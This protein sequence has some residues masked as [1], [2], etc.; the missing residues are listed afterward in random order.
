[1]LKHKIYLTGSKN[2]PCSNSLLEALALKLP[3]IVFDSGGHKDLKIEEFIL[4]IEKS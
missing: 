4:K 3:S 2:D 1:M